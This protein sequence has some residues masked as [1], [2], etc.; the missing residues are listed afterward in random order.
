MAASNSPMTLIKATVHIVLL[1]NLLLGISTHL[2]VKAAI[3]LGARCSDL[4]RLEALSDLSAWT[5]ASWG[6]SETSDSLHASGAVEIGSLVH[7][8]VPLPVSILVLS[9]HAT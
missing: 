2:L 7:I 4:A 6:S 9:R 5:R 8:V 1:C 3:L